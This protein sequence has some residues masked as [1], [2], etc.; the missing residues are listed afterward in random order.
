MKK[1]YNLLSI[2]PTRDSIKKK[3][4]FVE[5][6]VSKISPIQILTEFFANHALGTGKIVSSAIQLFN[7]EEIKSRQ[8]QVKFFQSLET[9]DKRKS[10]FSEIRQ[11]L[12]LYEIADQD[13]QILKKKGSMFELED[14]TAIDSG[15]FFTEVGGQR[16][17]TTINTSI[18]NQLS[19]NWLYEEDILKMNRIVAKTIFRNMESLNKLTRYLTVIQQICNDN[20][21][22]ILEIK[23]VMYLN[24]RLTH[25]VYKDMKSSYY[26]KMTIPIVLRKYLQRRGKSSLDVLIMNTT[27]EEFREV[28][29]L[30]SPKT[31]PEIADEVFNF[32]QTNTFAMMH[33]NLLRLAYF[34][35]MNESKWQGNETSIQFFR[36]LIKEEK[37]LLEIFLI[38]PMDEFMEAMLY[39]LRR[40]DEGTSGPTHHLYEKSKR[41]NL[42]NIVEEYRKAMTKK[43]DTIV[44]YHNRK[45][46]RQNEING[47]LDSFIIRKTALDED[48]GSVYYIY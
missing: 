11:E 34:W 10:Q 35:S 41:S 5:D 30:I 42:M 28:I 18:G 9:L 7:E 19:K 16:K 15:L 20:N 13:L 46:A 17:L 29:Q 31:T 33:F 32:L 22:A 8:L 43:H 27:I 21:Y 1:H 3:H 6:P 38:R 47:N 44:V 36:E 39:M 26:C 37:K 4:T 2:K 24:K 14:Y 45:E 40:I 23:D 48:N 25:S 12:D